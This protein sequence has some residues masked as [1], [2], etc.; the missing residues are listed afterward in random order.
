MQHSYTSE[1]VHLKIS[2][3]FLN[4]AASLTTYGYMLLYSQIVYNRL[5]SLNTTTA[6]SLR[7]GA[8]ASVL[9]WG[10]VHATILLYAT[11]PWPGL[12]SGWAK[13]VVLTKKVL[14]R[15]QKIAILKLFQTHFK[16]KREKGVGT[17][18]LRVPTPPQPWG[19]RTI[20]LRM[21]L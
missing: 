1:A 17:P 10:R 7:L 12:D 8:R 4:D 6:F 13:D 11:W 9:V 20:V 5:Y 2:T 3:S 19:W 15:I 21:C 14:E 18:F 16:A